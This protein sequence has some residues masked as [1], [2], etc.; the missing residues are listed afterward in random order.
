MQAVIFYL[1]RPT[2]PPRDGTFET[3]IRH[4]SQRR[5]DGG[6]A[7]AVGKA[8]ITA[9]PGGNRERAAQCGVFLSKLDIGLDIHNVVAPRI[10]AA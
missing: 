6:F 4:P 3:F 1:R 5:Y 9:L 2:L 7:L 10:G 8:E